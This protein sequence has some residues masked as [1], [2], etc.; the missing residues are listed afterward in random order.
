MRKSM[1]VLLSILVLALLP[2]LSS[3]QANGHSY[4]VVI[5]AGHGGQKFSGARYEGVLEKNINLKVAKKVAS[6]LEDEMPSLTVILTRTRE[7]QFSTVL[8]EDLQHVFA[9]PIGIS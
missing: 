7:M 1:I 3:A 8:T 5:D 9:F 4:V 2:A 6:L